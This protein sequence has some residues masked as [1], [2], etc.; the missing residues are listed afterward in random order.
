MVTGHKL[1]LVLPNLRQNTLA[2]FMTQSRC[3]VI[4][5]PG[6][7]TMAVLIPAC[8]ENNFALENGQPGDD[9]REAYKFQSDA[10]RN[11]YKLED[12]SGKLLFSFTET[13]VAY[14]EKENSSLTSEAQLDLSK[15]GGPSVK[16][17]LEEKTVEKWGINFAGIVKVTHSTGKEYTIFLPGTRTYDPAGLTGR[18]YLK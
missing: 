16:L 15:P 13:G 7:E 6:Y 10:V 5:T 4:R 8:F 1:V 18:H 9:L 17:E 11:L 3:G 2:R 14:N 12:A